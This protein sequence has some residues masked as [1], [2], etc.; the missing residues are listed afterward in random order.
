MLV[1]KKSREIN[2]QIL[3]TALLTLIA[4]L[5]LVWSPTTLA[6]PCALRLETPRF[7][8]L[9]YIGKSERSFRPRGQRS[10]PTLGHHRDAWKI[11]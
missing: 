1:G 3:K 8:M 9:S 10:L 7:L 2:S 5:G 4:R 11:S 6:S